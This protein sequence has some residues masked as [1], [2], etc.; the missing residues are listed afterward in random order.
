MSIIIDELPLLLTP[1]TLA[2]V[3]N[4]SNL[5][6]L[7]ATYFLPSENKDAETAFLTAHLPTAQRFDV[8]T[9]ADTTALLPH[10]LPLTAQAFE[11]H[12]HALGITPDNWLVIY[13]QKG[14]FSAPRVWWMLTTFGWHRVS[15][16][17]GGLPAWLKAGLPVETGKP[18]ALCNPTKQSLALVFNPEKVQTVE[19]MIQNLTNPHCLVLD[20]RSSGRFEGTAPEPRTSLKS[21]HIP[22]SRNLPFTELLTSDGFLK[23]T[24]ELDACFTNVGITDPMMPVACSCGSGITACVVALALAVQG[25]QGVV[26]V[27]DGSWLEWG[28]RNDTPVLTGV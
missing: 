1:E 4:A 20:A 25:H 11:G 24:V 26:S 21:G 16:L 12:L 28:G 18:A 22:N 5:V 17:Q 6:I 10:M 14:L 19:A 23:S 3:L 2:P 15:L 8:D 13:D 7:D 27:Y 9:I